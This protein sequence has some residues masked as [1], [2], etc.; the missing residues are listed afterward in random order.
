MLRRTV[1]APKSKILS[2]GSCGCGWI[3]GFQKR[4]HFFADF[5]E[6][7]GQAIYLRDG[8]RHL[9]AVA[10]DQIF[11]ARHGRQMLGRAVAQ[12]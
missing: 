4:A 1:G 5:I 9:R 6:C 2:I 11:P 12:L 8:G 3:A 10:H 7:R